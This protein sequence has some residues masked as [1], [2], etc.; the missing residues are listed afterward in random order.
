METGLLLNVEKASPLGL[1]LIAMMKFSHCSVA[2]FSN[3]SVTR[4]YGDFF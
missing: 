4:K 2:I 1:Y 3:V